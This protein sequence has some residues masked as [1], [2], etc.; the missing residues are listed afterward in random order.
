[1]IDFN[2]RFQKTW[3]RIPTAVKPSPG[4]AFLYYLRALNSDIAT[5]LQTMGGTTLPGAYDMAIRVENTLIQG[6]KIA[7]RP[8]MPLFPEIQNHQPS[9]API[10]TASS[11]QPL[12]AISLPSTSASEMS[13][14]ENM[15]QTLLQGLD[16]KLQEQSS[17]IKK[18][19]QE[20][21]SELKGQ[22][23]DQSIVVL[24]MGNE[25]T[26]LKKQQAQARLPPPQ[27]YNPP[28]FRPPY[29]APYPAYNNNI[30]NSGA[31]PVA[32]NPNPIRTIVPQNNMAQEQA[33]CP[34]C[35]Y[36][37]CACQGAESSHAL[38]TQ[39]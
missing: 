4:N 38:A 21:G 27:S 15:M 22:I 25:L 28:S 11:S 31:P 29:Q 9:I 3:D 24:K 32:T 30:S 26:N 36:E 14:L 35:S 17:E 8:P 2:Y 5:I 33:F 18:N 20:Q 19:L 37:H 39:D 12:A 1:M 23:Q 34:T 6:G 13:S 16:K 10:P 7:P